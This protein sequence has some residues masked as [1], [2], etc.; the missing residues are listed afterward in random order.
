MFD[1]LAN[2]KTL[3]T[4]EAG[5]T[6]SASLRLGEAGLKRL[7][8][9]TQLTGLRLSLVTIKDPATLAPFINMEMLDLNDAYVTDDIMPGLAGM[10]K[11]R[12]LTMVG[13]LI[14]DEGLRYLQDLTAMEELDLY[15]VRITDKG[16][17]YL[18]KLKRLRRLNLLGAQLTDASAGVLASLPELRDLNVYRSRLT[19]A[20]L[21]KLQT[22][23]NLSILDLRY[24]A[25][26]NAG[27]Q[28]F[29]AA[30]PNCK[31]NFVS[32]T[33]PV[34]GIRRKD[35][36]KSLTGEAIAAWVESLGGQAH[37]A[38]SRVT[39]ISLARVPF[40]DFQLASLK[41]LPAIERLNLEA[42]D[43]SD[44]G[45]SALSHLGAL[46]ELNLSFD[47]ISIVA[48]RVSQLLLGWSG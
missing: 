32:N 18:Q 41:S 42:T 23:R 28:A 6:P 31:V 34:S 15:G 22:L 48:W 43:V 2:S 30:R 37:L 44:L 1:Y 7:S 8:R 4:F 5:L 19:N 47:S 3:L 24:T 10:K 16:V 39:A 35:N 12:R 17:Q 27:V 36:P 29:S 25:V 33:A 26:T 40:T 45:L 13:T 46:R 38:E 11:L 20:G 21:A 14:T 9:L